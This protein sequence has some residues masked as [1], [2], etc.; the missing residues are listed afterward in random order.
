MIGFQYALSVHLFIC[1]LVFVLQKKIN[2]LAC[3][4]YEGKRENNGIRKVKWNVELGLEDQ[5]GKY[6]G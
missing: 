4:K 2:T 5:V 6:V 1:L 3:K